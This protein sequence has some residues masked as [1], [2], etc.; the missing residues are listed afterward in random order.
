MGLA[1]VYQKLVRSKIAGGPFR[2]MRYGPQT[3]CGPLAA[4]LLGTYELELAAAL[5]EVFRAGHDT[6][7]D[8]GA[9]EG[10]YAVGMAL[11][12]PGARIVAFESDAFAQ[13]LLRKN[14]ALNRVAERIEIRGHCDPRALADA[15]APARKPFVLVDAEGAET[16][17]L[18]PATV[19]DLARAVVMVELH[20]FADPRCG[21]IIRER[22]QTSHDIEEIRQRPRTR[23]DLPRRGSLFFLSHFFK[24]R[25]VQWMDEWRPE[26]MRWFYMK[27][28]Q[29][30]HSR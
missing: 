2:G 18:D 21:D 26:P 25:G 27:P 29:T 16:E 11:R 1:N 7:I 19:H 24:H 10:Y 3:V 14:A 4:K 20:D 28:K 5:E 12:N 8:V 9:A 17:L 6:L 22:C 23:D 13:K 30:S 15:L